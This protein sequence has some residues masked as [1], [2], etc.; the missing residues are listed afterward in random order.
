MKTPMKLKAAAC[1]AIA[2]GAIGLATYTPAV[3]ADNAGLDI[4][5]G[6]R[7]QEKGGEALYRAVCQSCHMDKGQ[8]AKGAGMYPA[9]ASN[10]RLAASTYPVYNIVHGR[11]GM[12]PFGRML[13]DEQ[14]ADVTNYV[15]TH[16]GNDYKDAV[17]PEMVKSVR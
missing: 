2:M 1:A 12:P 9:L 10:P 6:F 17:T 16:M 8:G 11:K 7:F 5:D 15:R 3:H 14:I 13:S 4:S